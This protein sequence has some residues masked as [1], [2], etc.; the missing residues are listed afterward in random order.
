M[1]SPAESLG[2]PAVGAVGMATRAHRCRDATLRRLRTVL[3]SEPN[4]SVTEP[5]RRRGHDKA[6]YALVRDAIRRAG[7]A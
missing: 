6:F 5:G 7:D 3:T 1:W 2:R 4:A